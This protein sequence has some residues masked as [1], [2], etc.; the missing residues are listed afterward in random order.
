MATWQIHFVPYNLFE[1][2]N[3]ISI[4]GDGD[5]GYPETRLYDRAKNLYWQRTATAA[6]TYKLDMGAGNTA[7]ADILIVSGHNWN[8]ETVDWQ[9]D[10]DDSG[11]T[12]VV[13]QFSATTADI[14]QTVGT[15][16]DDRYHQVVVSS[17]DNPRA[18]EIC[19][20]LRYSFDADR[21]GPPAIGDAANVEWRK[22]IDGYSRSVKYG[23]A[24]KTFSYT[25]MLDA[26]DLASFIEMCGYLEGFSLP[27]W[28]V[29]HLGAAYLVRFDGPPAK[30]Y[31]QENNTQIQV[32]LVE[33]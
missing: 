28:F 18:A 22:L 31:M 32:N 3:A 15:P 12:N 27:F 16:V 6:Q 25:L 9:H 11:Y 8:G 5:S 21:S 30:S 1:L 4:T 24:K 26:T 10:D 14:L 20:G 13:S 7:E 29:D 2:A 33:I 17:M 23:P 19:I